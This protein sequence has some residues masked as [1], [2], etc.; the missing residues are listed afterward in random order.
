MTRRHSFLDTLHQ[1]EAQARGAT[2][3]VAE[4]PLHKLGALVRDYREPPIQ[5]ADLYA[6]LDANFER[7]KLASIP[8]PDTSGPGGE[9]RKL[10]HIIRTKA[11]EREQER[12]EKAASI[13]TA[14]EGLTLLAD[15]LGSR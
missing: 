8:P 4:R 13:L 10:A 2:A 1:I 3:D 14:A 9:F 12:F 6:V 15:L 11:V 5:Y 7:P